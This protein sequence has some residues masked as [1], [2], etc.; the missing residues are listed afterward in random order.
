MCPT[1]Y[2]STFSHFFVQF[3]DVLVYVYVPPRQPLVS[4]L[5]LLGLVFEYIDRWVCVWI[6]WPLWL[7]FEYIDR[8][9]GFVVNIC[10]TCNLQILYYRCVVS[11]CENFQKVVT[12][13]IVFVDII[14]FN[15]W[16]PEDTCRQVVFL[17]TSVKKGS[18]C[19]ILR[20][21]S[22]D[23][24]LKFRF[25]IYIDSTISINT[26]ARFWCTATDEGLLPE[27]IV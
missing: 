24:H 11:G 27:T 5:R 15:L 16:V 1:R 3:Q 23:S 9:S 2:S 7:V 8:S 26:I 22:A 13:V 4:G 20:S 12:V 18:C 25:N 10:N 17:S 14:N 19:E 21:A 6:Y